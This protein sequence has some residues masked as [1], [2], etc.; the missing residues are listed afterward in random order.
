MNECKTNFQAHEKVHEIKGLKRGVG[1]KES[2][3]KNKKLMYITVPI[4]N[5]VFPVC[6]VCGQQYLNNSYLKKHLRLHNEGR[7][8]IICDGFT[9]IPQNGDGVKKFNYTKIGN[10]PKEYAACKICNKSYLYP[11]GIKI[12]TKK[13]HNQK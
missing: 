8:N 12:H 11:R 3:T 7:T 6:K 1:K 9:I 5:K 2:F 13:M 4:G 10:D